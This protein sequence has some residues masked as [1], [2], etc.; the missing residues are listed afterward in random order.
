MLDIPNKEVRIGL[1]K[2]LMPHYISRPTSETN[3]MVAYLSQDIQNGDMEDSRCM[4][5]KLV[6]RN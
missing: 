5:K 2:S 1:M 4:N 6:M 3:T